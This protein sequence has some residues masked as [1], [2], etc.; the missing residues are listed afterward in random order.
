MTLFPSLRKFLTP[1][2]AWECERD[3]LC[4]WFSCQTGGNVGAVKEWEHLGWTVDV[5]ADVTANASQ[6]VVEGGGPAPC[7][8]SERKL[9]K[10]SQGEELAS[11]LR[12]C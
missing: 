12:A 2:K 8:V 3:K 1:G 10:P 6:I 5:L 9:H 7:P 11:H 4:F